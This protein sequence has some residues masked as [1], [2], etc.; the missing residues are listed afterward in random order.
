MMDQ[1]QTPR[2]FDWQPPPPAQTQSDPLR[3]DYSPITE[4]LA[5]FDFDTVGQV[6]L[7]LNWGWQMNDGCRPPSV[8]ELR[9]AAYKMLCY[10]NLYNQPIAGGGL[11]VSVTP[12]GQLSLAFVL[13]QAASTDF[14]IYN[15]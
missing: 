3:P 8:E 7:A 11:E 4:V 6:M 5:G 1:T 14:G 13:E 12:R 10:A 2:F 9:T 15:E